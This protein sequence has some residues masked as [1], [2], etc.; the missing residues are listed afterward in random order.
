MKIAIGMT[1][2]EMLALF[3]ARRLMRADGANRSWSVR[4]RV[5]ARQALHECESRIR[6]ELAAGARHR[7]A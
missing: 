4:M 1:R 2:T 3:R 5:M 7:P 6:C